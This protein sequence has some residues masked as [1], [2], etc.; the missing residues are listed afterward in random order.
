MNASDLRQVLDQ[1]V[2]MLQNNKA[3]VTPEL[4]DAAKRLVEQLGPV[5]KDNQQFQNVL[6]G[7]GRVLEIEDQLIN[8]NLTERL[9]EILTKLQNRPLILSLVA[10]LL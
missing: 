8:T 4:L 7:A 1:A 3:A 5:M 2:N 10:R 9:T 6:Q